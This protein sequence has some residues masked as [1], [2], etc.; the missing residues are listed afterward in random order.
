MKYN[1]Q[2]LVRFIAT[3]LNNQ[4]NKFHIL[5]VINILI[6]EMLN[7]LKSGKEVKI[8]N[9]GTFSIKGLKSKQIR[10]VVSKKLINN[11]SVKSLRFS[12]SKK[13]SKLILGDK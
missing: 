13:L 5:S 11:S 4:I 12:L 2:N 9:F 1:K 10:N 6:D 7:D 3:K 8:T